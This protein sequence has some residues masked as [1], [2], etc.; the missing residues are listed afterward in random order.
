MDAARHSW[1]GKTPTLKH[2]ENSQKLGKATFWPIPPEGEERVTNGRFSYLRCAILHHLMPFF[3]YSYTLTLMFVPDHL[4]WNVIMVTT[5]PFVRIHCGVFLITTRMRMWILKAAQTHILL[6]V[7]GQWGMVWRHGC[8]E[9]VPKELGAMYDVQVC[10]KCEWWTELTGDSVINTH[11]LTHSWVRLFWSAK[12]LIS[13][14]AQG[15]LTLMMEARK[16][17]GRRPSGK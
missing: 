3:S 10:E 7:Q 12:W 6:P 11:R 1:F 2:G 9:A 16:S 14:I 8:T 15:D 5:I 13:Q 4:R 17:F